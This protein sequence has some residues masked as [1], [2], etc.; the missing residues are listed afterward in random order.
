[1]VLLIKVVNLVIGILSA[2]NVD[3]CE[4]RVWQLNGVSS[5]CHFANVNRMTSH[6]IH[7]LKK[8]VNRIIFKV[9]LVIL[10]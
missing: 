7:I 1:M 2:E 8:N 9:I 4:L 6:P 5:G 10:I 3:F